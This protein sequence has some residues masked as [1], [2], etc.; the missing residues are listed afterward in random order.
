MQL[1][2]CTIIRPPLPPLPLLLL[3]AIRDPPRRPT[4]PLRILTTTARARRPRLRWDPTTTIEGTHLS[5]PLAPPSQIRDPAL[6]CALCII[7]V[8][9]PCLLRNQSLRDIEK[10]QNYSRTQ[11]DARVLRVQLVCAAVCLHEPNKKREG[12]T[13]GAVDNS[14]PLSAWPHVSCDAVVVVVDASATR[15]AAATM[16]AAARE[17]TA[18]ATTMTRTIP[19]MTPLALRRSRGRGASSAIAFAPCISCCMC[20]TSSP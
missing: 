5:R 4:R 18:E 19:A 13:P 14:P 15:T 17:G 12:S 7:F 8:C 9:H 10:N 3:R 11:R 6:S 20:V 2:R 16:V 1:R